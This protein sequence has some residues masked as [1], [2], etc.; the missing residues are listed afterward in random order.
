MNRLEVIAM[1]SSLKALSK[2][3]LYDE[4]D[5]VIDKTLEAAMNE[6][7]PSKKKEFEE[8]DK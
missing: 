1:F 4:L 6:K 3:K 7:Q 2:N 5:D 8:N